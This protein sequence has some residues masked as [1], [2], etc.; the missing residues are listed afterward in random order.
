MGIFSMMVPADGG[1]VD[2][3]VDGVEHS[4]EIKKEEDEDNR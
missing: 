3:L 1:G 2:R 4:R